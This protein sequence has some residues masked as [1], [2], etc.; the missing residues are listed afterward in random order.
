MKAFVI[1]LYD[2]E[3]NS[4]DAFDMCSKLKYNILNR[5]HTQLNTDTNVVIELYKIFDKNFLNILKEFDFMSIQ[6]KKLLY[7]HKNAIDV[8][9]I[10]SKTDI[11]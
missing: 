4:S 11:N 1:Y 3:F 8:S 9:S 6:N 7:E 5:I 10:V 2:K